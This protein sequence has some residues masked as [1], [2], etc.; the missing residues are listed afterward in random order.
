MDEA[1]YEELMQSVTPRESVGGVRN[2][3]NTVAMAC[4]ACDRPFDDLV[5]CT[6]EYNSLELSKLL[7][8]CVTTHDDDVL[9][10]THKP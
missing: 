6:E 10:F 2:Y 5:V 7:D 3:Q 9:L 4:P 8:L 1:T